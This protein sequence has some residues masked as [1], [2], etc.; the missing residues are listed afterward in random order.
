M[1]NFF[2]NI[3]KDLELK[4]NNSSNGD[5]LEDVLKVFNAQQLLKVLGQ[6]SKL[7][8]SFRFNK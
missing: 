5:T 1:N 2:I 4:E 8:K 6:T 7:M 3:I